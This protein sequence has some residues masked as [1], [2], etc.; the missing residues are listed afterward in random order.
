M[1]HR[2]VAT[3]AALAILMLEPLA[4]TAATVATGVPFEIN[5]VLPTTGPAAFLGSKEA[6]G[7]LLTWFLIN[8]KKSG[9]P[10]SSSARITNLYQTQLK[11]IE[12]TI[13]ELDEDL[14]HDYR[15]ELEE[16]VIFL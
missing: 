15:K 13:A 6:E 7:E 1:V 12:K 11:K 5:A 4:A 9:I 3:L 16:W 2:V 8:I 10:V 14:Q